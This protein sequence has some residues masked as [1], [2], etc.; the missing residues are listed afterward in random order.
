MGEFREKR[1]AEGA[2]IVAQLQGVE[3]QIAGLERSVIEA[4]VPP[5]G[6]ITIERALLTS[7]GDEL[8]VMTERQ[9]RHRRPAR[10][11]R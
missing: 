3:E 5:P 8:K 1:D 2:A 4:A 10:H 11:A 9:V 7:V 6:L